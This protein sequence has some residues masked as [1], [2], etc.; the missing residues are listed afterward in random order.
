MPIEFSCPSCHLRYSVKDELAGKGAKCGKCGHRMKIPQLAEAKPSTRPAAK[1]TAKST[2]A[3]TSATA[4]TKASVPSAPTAPKKAP[5]ASPPKKPAPIAPPEDDFGA[6]WLDEDLEKSP[7]AMAPLPRAAT[8]PACGT[9]LPSGSV[10]CVTCGYDTRTGAQHE[11]VHELEP[12]AGGKK[13]KSK[14]GKAGSLLRGTLFSFLAAVLGA[15]IWAVLAYFTHREF[16]IVAWAFGGLVGF[17]MALGHED[18]DGTFAGIIAAF[19]SLFGILA[20]KILIIVIFVGAHVASVVGDFEV[21]LKRAAVTASIAQEKLKADGVDVEKAS[22]EQM[23][24]AMAAARAEVDGLSEEAL[25]EKFAQWEKQAEEEELAAEA[26]EPAA[27]EP[28]NAEV[29]DDQAA[30]P[31]DAEVADADAAA[32]DIADVADVDAAALPVDDEEGPE[33][34]SVLWE[35]FS[36]IDGLFILLA[37]FTAYK[38]GSG[39]IGD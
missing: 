22:E 2:V 29:A 19:M 28:G 17:G 32:P 7:A 14:L 21:Q 16:G 20:A 6:S 9:A 13:K 12:V 31:A 18:D 35:M 34:L 39:E 15:I 27:D 33:F 30:A 36:P 26:G 37:F 5:L 1:P 11:T 4:S 38:V 8:C 3:K 24:A 23:E 10:L 25:E